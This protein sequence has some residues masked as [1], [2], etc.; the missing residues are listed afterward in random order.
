MTSVSIPIKVFNPVRKRESKTFLLNLHIER[1]GNLKCLREDILEQLGKRVV[2]FDLQFDVGY[3]CGSRKICF[4]DSDDMKAE[5]NRLN[6]SGKSLWCEGLQEKCLQE[7]HDVVCLDSD[8]EED[9]M[10]KAKKPKVCVDVKDKIS[11]H[12]PDKINAYEAKVK[13]VDTLANELRE[14]HKEKYNKIQCKLW[15]EALDSGKHLSKEEPPHGSIWG[16]KSMPG[17]KKDSVDAMASAFTNMANT[18]A[19]AFTNH[20]VTQKEANSPNTPRKGDSCTHRTVGVSP[21]RRIDYQ[22]KLFNQIDMLHKMYERGALT[23]EQFEKRR[24]LLLTQLDS[25]SA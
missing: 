7:K 18:V 25:L 10:P 23:S 20:P 22:D 21:G 4:G 6:I 12:K 8:S 2:K 1:I 15:A 3:C 16:S 9:S 5:L 14:K 17:K 11:G 24:E 13:R 19:S